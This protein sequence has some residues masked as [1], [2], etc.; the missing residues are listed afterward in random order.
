DVL[1]DETPDARGPD[2]RARPV[3]L[4]ERERECSRASGEGVALAFGRVQLLAEGLDLGAQRLDGLVGGLHRGRERVVFAHGFGVALEREE[5]VA[6]GVAALLGLGEGGTL[7]LG[8]R[9]RR[10]ETGL[11][12][13]DDT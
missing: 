3:A 4:I 2:D 13:R 6:R 7:A 10:G 9:T 12:G 8:L 1:G 5:L 11:R